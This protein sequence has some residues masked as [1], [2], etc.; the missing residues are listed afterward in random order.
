MLSD[1]FS[2]SFD[3]FS[4]SLAAQALQLSSPARKSQSYTAQ[5]T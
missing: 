5:R 2:H 1:A 3:L 4:H